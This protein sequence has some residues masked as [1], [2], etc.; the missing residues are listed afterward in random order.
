MKNFPNVVNEINRTLNQ[1][2]FFENIVNT[3]LVFLVFYLIFSVFNVNPLFAFIPAFGYLGYY[4]YL[5]FKSYKPGMVESKYAPLRE[6]LRTAADNVGMESPIAEELAYEVTSEMKNVGISLFI[7][8]KSL[9][10]KIFAV[11]LL[12]FLIIFATTLD[13]RLFEFARQKI[14]DIFDTKNL[15]GVGNF[16]AVQLNTSDDIYGNKDVAKLGDKELN[17]RIKP[18][19]FKVNVKEEGDVQ[20]HEFKTVFPSELTVKESVTYEE[21]IPQEQQELVKNYFK[22]LAEEGQ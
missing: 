19:D 11:M 14:P 21:N 13:L 3:T 16:I 6:K 20:Q 1:L 18:V 2:I 15:K 8:P 22:K 12:S 5:S 4:S 10:Y 7:N 17:I 9:S